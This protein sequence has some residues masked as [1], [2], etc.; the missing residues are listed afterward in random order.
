[1]AGFATGTGQ[2]SIQFPVLLA[3]FWS[4]VPRISRIQLKK[5]VSQ[6]LIVGE[7]DLVRAVFVKSVG[8]L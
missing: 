2:L 7:E 5:V 8:R 3:K 1:M 6:E 4:V